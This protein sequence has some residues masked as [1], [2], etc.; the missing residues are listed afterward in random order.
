MTQHANPR[1]HKEHVIRG[2]VAG[3]GAHLMFS[4]MIMQAKVLSENHSVIEI[5]FYRNL[6]GSLPFIFIVFAMGRRHILKLKTKPALVAIRAMLGT[7]S[8][9]VTFYAFSLMPMADATALMFASSLFIP[10]LAVVVLKES[11]GP[12]RW[13]AVAV[14]FVGV[15]IMSRPTGDVYILAV[16][17]ALFAAMM[18]A[19]LQIILRY[20][21]KYES[22]E[23]ISFYFF[24]IGTCL[25]AVAMPFVAVTPTLSEIPLLLGVGLAGAAAQWLLS[26]AYVNAP[27]AVVSVFNYTSIIWATLF[28][29]MIWGDWPTLAVFGGAS[30]V[31][32]SSVLIIW[33][34]SRQH[35]RALREES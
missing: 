18:H 17:V 31:I 32:S 8:L 10:V 33:R 4:I 23:T 19:V 1:A 29:W 11:V 21:G 35:K 15:T 22:P 27:A 14:G 2:M 24:I 6:I 13:A 3:L 7:V 28:G 26:V 20:V 34:E 5:A 12:Y 9:V 30:I 25:T 16:S